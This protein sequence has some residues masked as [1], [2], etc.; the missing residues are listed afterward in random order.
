MMI[1]NGFIY[2]PNYR[3]NFRKSIRWVTMKQLSSGVAVFRRISWY[4][5]R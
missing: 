3:V 4:G 2:D 1:K 5:D